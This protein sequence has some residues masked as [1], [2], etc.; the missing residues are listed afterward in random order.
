M[1]YTNIET[2]KKIITQLY[3]NAHDVSYITHSYDN[4]VALV[5]MQFAVRFPQSDGAHARSQFEREVLQKLESL[6]VVN[7]P[8]ALESS[9]NPPYLVTSFIPGQHL[10]PLEVNAFTAEKQEK[11]G[12]KVAEFAHAMHSSLSVN[13]AIV[14]RKK[15]KLDSQAEE[16]WEVYIKKLIYDRQ[17]PTK[18]Q[19]DSAKEYYDNWVKSSYSTP[20][21]VLHDDLH[22]E[23]MMFENGCLTGI[24]D[25]GDTNIGHPEQELRQLYR[26]NETIL[27]FAASKY[28]RLS[29]YQLN[30]EA[31]KTWAVIQE[32]GV[33][34]EHISKDDT[35]HP[36]FH[37]A[38][39]NLTN[40]L[41]RGEW[42]IEAE[43]NNQSVFRQ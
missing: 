31:I 21:V 37:R 25:F 39:K 30:R 35:K 14:S 32:M 38:S 18:E 41:G 20:K 6:A 33:Y 42:I 22:T 13:E 8:K 26:I 17:L 27:E 3:P 34:M 19:D 10:S 43:V 4:I 28:E 11:F 29:G 7:I 36:A 40:W 12:H 2:I 15:L 23:N 16:P 9:H 1:T 24:L 5:N